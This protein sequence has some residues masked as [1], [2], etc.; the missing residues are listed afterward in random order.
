MKQH[1]ANVITGSRIILSVLML[2]FP[3]FS[4]WFYVMY[5]AGGITDMID[6]IVARKTKSVSVFGSRLDTFADFVFIS[7]A[8]IKILPVAD[9]SKWLLVWISAI[10]FIKI[11]NIILG[12]IRM[13]RFIAAHTVMNKITG[14]LL[15]LF[16]LTFTYVK[17]CCSAFAICIIATIAAIQE[18]YYIGKGI[19]V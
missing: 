1:A 6:G 12:F 11:L 5:F 13:K 3:V 18:G 17:I 7:L 19:K 9:V 16:P 14:F 10:A 2:M 8:L 4:F 15:F